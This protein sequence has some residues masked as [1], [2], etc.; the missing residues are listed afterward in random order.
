MS[1]SDGSAQH[2]HDD[3]DDEFYTSK[4]H[5]HFLQN[6]F[7]RYF[8]LLYHFIFSIL[9]TIFLM[10]GGLYGSQLKGCGYFILLIYSFIYFIQDILF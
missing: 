9:Q 7:W 4:Q 8:I 10:T 5:L 1:E 3:D 2:L 6:L